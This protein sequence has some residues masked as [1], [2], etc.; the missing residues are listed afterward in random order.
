M[1]SFL[2]PSPE[3]S[4]A[5]YQALIS[6]LREEKEDG[7]PPEELKKFLKFQLD[8][9]TKVSVKGSIHYLINS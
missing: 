3:A 9:L 7:D 2:L 4:L 6:Q 5:E 1:S 8:V